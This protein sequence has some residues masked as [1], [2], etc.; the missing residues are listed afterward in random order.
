LDFTFINRSLVTNIGKLSCGWSFGE[1][2]LEHGNYTGELEMIK[3][4]KQRFIF[5]YN[6]DVADFV[7]L[8]ETLH[9]VLYEF[10]KVHD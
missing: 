8:M 6:C 10:G 9:S 2:D 5:I 1:S 3:S 7:Y 4:F